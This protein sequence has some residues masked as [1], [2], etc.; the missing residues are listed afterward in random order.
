M[1]ATPS[2][3]VARREV[4]LFFLF[5]FVLLAAGIGLRDPWPSDEP[6]FTLV[7]KQMVE[8]GDWLIPRRGN[9]LY[10]DKPPLFMDLQALSFTLVRDWRVA[11]LL[12][13]LLATLGTLWLVYDLGRRL[14]DRRAGLLAA[15][16]TLF[17]VGFTFQA[18]R[19][20]IDPTVTFFITLA[21]Y[22]LLRH[23]L[24]GPDWR[25]W[26]LGGVAAG[27]GVI[28][29]GVGVLAFLTVLPWLWWR[30]RLRRAHA[31]R[32]P[33]AGGSGT[34][35]AAYAGGW[36][37]LLAPALCVFTVALWLVPLLIVAH[38]SH[39]AAY[40]AYLDNLLFKQ[41]AERYAAAWHHQ[42]PP[43]YYLEVI[44]LQW[45]PL[46]LFL[47]WLAPAW[48]R[49]LRDGDPRFVLLLGF[50]V[51]LL[52]FFNLS[53]G[54]REVYILP[55]LPMLALAAAPLITDILVQ[56]RWP[57]RLLW[58]L[59]AAFATA[60]LAVGLRAW[61]I[62]PQWGQRLLAARDVGL[63]AAA[64]WIWL[65]GFGAAA[66]LACVIARP[67]RP[68][69]AA[70]ATLGLFWI[71]V[72]IGIMPALNDS[73]S[74]RGLM[75]AVGERIGADA[76][77][78]LVGWR[79]QQLLQA[80]R[81]AQTF[82]FSRDPSAQLQD[83]LIWQAQAPQRWLLVQAAALAACPPR[84]DAIDLG[85]GNRREWVLLPPDPGWRCP[86]PARR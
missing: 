63:T 11:F 86:V 60:A 75:R 61:W 78:G 43:W 73:S 74:G 14:W 8:S 38:A 6:R 52:V 42:Q 36:R 51:L 79:E 48:W 82:G 66:L 77:L 67:G 29:K 57:G 4:A 80:D 62:D 76:G 20:Q 17:A 45:L 37:W 1:N 39:D 72:G 83:A 34:G 46:S 84:A 40:G 7:A 70:S 32:I 15:W 58:A 9:E 18:K 85:L 53:A 49:K 55:G 69:L 26:A 25:R 12:P 35:L 21:N 50:V 31:D 54:K 5:A 68:L 24:Q 59:C 81:P 64:V 44:A 71:C 65:A 28:T 16:L 33:T 56:H 27:L 47:P 30:W 13:S 19:A 41:T 2:A 23:L 3:R 22:G 10:A